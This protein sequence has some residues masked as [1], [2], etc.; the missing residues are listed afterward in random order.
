M[1]KL[2]LKELYKKIDDENELDIE[3][4]YFFGL[5]QAVKGKVKF[6]REFLECRLN[7]EEHIYEKCRCF[8][9]PD[10]KAFVHE[11]IDFWIVKKSKT[12]GK[13]S[14]IK[15]NLIMKPPEP[16]TPGRKEDKGTPTKSTSKY[17]SLDE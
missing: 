2:E 4:D 15:K 10:N 12:N 3:F 6:S 11:Y 14:E 1:N 7:M 8:I 17:A 13:R 9:L 5:L 16:E